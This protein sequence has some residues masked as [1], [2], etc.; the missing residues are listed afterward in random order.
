MYDYKYRQNKNGKIYSLPLVFFQ[1]QIKGEKRGNHGG[2]K[3]SPHNVIYDFQGPFFRI[4]NDK[5]FIV[6]GSNH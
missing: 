3:Q 4:G 5:T 2:Q 6:A 1:A